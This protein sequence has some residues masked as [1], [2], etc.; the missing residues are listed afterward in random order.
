MAVSTDS[1][2]IVVMIGPPM[3]AC[4]TT[5]AASSG[6]RTSPMKSMSVVN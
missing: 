3:P 1:A 4:K 6:P 2:W 5:A